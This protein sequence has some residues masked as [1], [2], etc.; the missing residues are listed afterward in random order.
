MIGAGLMI[1]ATATGPLLGGVLLVCFVG[2]H[3]W[4][5]HRRR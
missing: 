5:A 2:F 1:T 4:S 3:L